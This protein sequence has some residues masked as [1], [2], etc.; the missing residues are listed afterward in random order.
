MQVPGRD[1]LNVLGDFNARANIGRFPAVTKVANDT[2]FSLQYADDAVLPSHTPGDLQRQL[3]AIVSA[4]SR[5]GLVVNSKETEVIYPPSDSSP[6]PTFFINGDQ[7][8]PS[9][10]I[11]L[12]H[13]W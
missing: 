1:K 10:V 7:P 6:P 9:V 3:D 11:N 2:I 13:Q 5:A 8:F 4:Y 12:F